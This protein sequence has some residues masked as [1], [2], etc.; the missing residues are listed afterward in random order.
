MDE[1]RSGFGPVEEQTFEGINHDHILDGM[2]QGDVPKEIETAEIEA[3]QTRLIEAVQMSLPGLAVGQPV[4]V[5]DHPAGR[6]VRQASLAP[7]TSWKA[8]RHQGSQTQR[9]YYVADNGIEISL[10]TLDNP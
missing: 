1:Q 10:G 8:G 7:K 2:L 6:A 9:L 4:T 3:T 5:L